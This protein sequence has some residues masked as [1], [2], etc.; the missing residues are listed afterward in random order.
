MHIDGGRGMKVE[1]EEHQWGVGNVSGGRGM[2]VGVVGAWACAETMEGMSITRKV[3]M[4]TMSER[5]SQMLSTTHLS[6]SCA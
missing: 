6:C 5:N 1:A 2:S 3:Y 4:T